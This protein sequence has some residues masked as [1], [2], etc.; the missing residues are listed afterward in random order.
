MITVFGIKY[1][2]A[3]SDETPACSDAI[4]GYISVYF[5]VFVC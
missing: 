5:H 1:E 4:L 2:K 3:S